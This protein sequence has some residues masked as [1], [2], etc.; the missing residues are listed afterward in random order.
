MWDGYLNLG[1]F[2]LIGIEYDLEQHIDFP[3]L[4][5]LDYRPGIRIDFLL[6][7]LIKP[8]YGIALGYALNSKAL[9][10][11]LKK[12]CLRKMRQLFF[13]LNKEQ[14]QG[15]KNKEQ[16]QKSKDRINCLMFSV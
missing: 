14:E 9:M 8:Y 10:L 7:V 1:G 11:I 13:A 3:L 12:S 4:L 2:G 15:T 16:R 5:S 6:T